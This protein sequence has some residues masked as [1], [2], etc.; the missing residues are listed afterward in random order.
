MRTDAV[1][2][3]RRNQRQIAPVTIFDGILREGG[4]KTD[5]TQGYTETAFISEDITP[6][7]I[8][9]QCTNG[10]ISQLSKSHLQTNNTMSQQ[11]PTRPS[12]QTP[13]YDNI[14]A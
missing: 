3:L 14:S 4:E 2:H 8:A 11:V 5:A 12:Y 13:V 9:Q 7:D 1:C 10:V 6:N